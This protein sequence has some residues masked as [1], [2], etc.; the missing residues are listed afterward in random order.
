MQIS[1]VIWFYFLTIYNKFIDFIELGRG[2]YSTSNLS[3]MTFLAEWSGTLL[4]S[5]LMDLS[6][7]S[8]RVPSLQSSEAQTQ[9]KVERYL[10]GGAG[11]SVLLILLV[12]S[13]CLDL[14]SEAGENSTLLF[15]WNFAFY[16]V[17]F[18]SFTVFILW[19]IAA[20]G[21]GVRSS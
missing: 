4:G 11:A 15:V 17:L 6:K 8:S 2:F 19:Q 13:R 16:D 1:L 18:F 9:T 10:L 21:K 7:M 12:L 5:C 20:P 14:I 3:T